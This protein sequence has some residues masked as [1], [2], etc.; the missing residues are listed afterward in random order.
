MNHYLLQWRM[1][2]NKE[3][4]CAYT[5]YLIKQYTPHM[6]EIRLNAIFLYNQWWD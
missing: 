3:N 1:C 2:I 5:I 4:I 6:L